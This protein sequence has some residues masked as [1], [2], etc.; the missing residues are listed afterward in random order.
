[1]NYRLRLMLAFA[2]AFTAAVTAASPVLAQKR[3]RE[4][5]Q[6]RN[7]VKQLD[8]AES[9]IMGPEA[10]DSLYG[11]A[12]DFANEEIGLRDENPLGYLLAGR[13]FLGLRRF[14]EASA[15]LDKA[16]ELRPVYVQETDVVRETG[17]FNQYEAAQPLLSAFEYAQAAEELELAHVIYKKRPEIMIVLGQLYV[18]EAGAATD[19]AARLEATDKAI[20]RLN[21]ADGVIKARISEVDSTLAEAWR[22]QQ[23]EIHVTIAQALI[24]AERFDEASAA[25]R[26]LVEVNPDNLRYAANLGSI[27][28]Q[29]GKP[30]SAKAVYSRLLERP[31]LTPTH[32]Y[33]FGSGLYQVNEYRM[34]ADVFKRGADAAPKD[35]DAIEMWARSVLLAVSDGGVEATP[36]EAQEVMDAAERWIELD[37]YGRDGFVILTRFVN[38]AGD[39][40]RTVE[41]ITKVDAMTVVVRDLLLQRD[42]DG[43]ADVVGM[44]MNVKA[45][46][47]TPVTMVFTFYDQAGNALGTQTTMV[48]AGAVDTSTDI[49][50]RFDSDSQVD[51]YGYTLSM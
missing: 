20:A 17:W 16:E 2:L 12:L 47:G 21:E 13:A 48:T 41:L 42:A 50:L 36:E 30:D 24:S 27:Y 26:G 34:A 49:E 6:T 51:G 1:M 33:Q 37:P 46:P 5:N 39:E 11:L 31:D 8:M 18:A 45:D 29:V 4:T 25:L 32:F 15:A 40:P 23:A 38:T 19:P 28:A 9:G 3:P 22:E 10:A 44:L 14:A 43:G 7:A 35:R